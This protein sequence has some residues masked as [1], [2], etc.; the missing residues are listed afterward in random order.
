VLN[1]FGVAIISTPKGL[2]TDIS[3]R[4]AKLGGEVICE[5]Y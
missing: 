4:A 3:A 5:V 1:G 2:M